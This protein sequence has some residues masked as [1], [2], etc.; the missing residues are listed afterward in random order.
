[1][2]DKSEIRIESLVPQTAI[3]LRY[4]LSLISI[5]ENEN[6]AR[7]RI[8]DRATSECFFGP[9]WHSPDAVYDNTKSEETDDR[10]SE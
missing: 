3:A 10:Y 5:F 4:G 7:K 8:A 9:W 1:M 6:T 2:P